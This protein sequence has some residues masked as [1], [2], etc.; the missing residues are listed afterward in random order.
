MPKISK[1][2]KTNMQT[3]ERVRI[4]RTMQSILREEKNSM[5]NFI[6][7]KK[8]KKSL[9]NEANN[10][11]IETNVQKTDNVT[12]ENSFIDELRSWVIQFHI[13]RRSVSKLLNLLRKFGWKY[14]PKDSR[15]LMITPRSVEIEEKAGGKMWY[16]GIKNNL[17]S[18]FSRLNRDIVVELNFNIDGLPLFKSSLLSFWPILANIHG[19]YSTRKD[20]LYIVH[21]V[22]ITLMITLMITFMILLFIML[23]KCLHFE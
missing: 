21:I 3:R 13:T 14:L 22:V 16:N 8:L 12:S 19:M 6:Y 18:I 11:F 5:S 1:N 7:T 10:H 17:I 15:T 9:S 20:C 2:T 4:H 23:I